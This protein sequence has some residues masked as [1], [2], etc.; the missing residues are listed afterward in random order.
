MRMFLGVKS[1]LYYL[2]ALAIV[3]F[4][5]ICVRFPFD[6][7]IGDLLWAED[8]SIFLNQAGE[9]GLQSLMQ[10][11]AGYL[12]IYPRLFAFLVNWVGLGSAPYLLFFGWAISA[13]TLFYVVTTRLTSLGINRWVA[14]VPAI[15]VFLQPN[16]GEV[17]FNITNAQWF[18]GASLAVMVCIDRSPPEGCLGYACLFVFCLTGPFSAL[19]LPVLFWRAIFDSNVY[20]H[21]LFYCFFVGLACVQLVV[22][23][24]SSRGASDQ[25]D[26]DIF[27][28]A[29]AVYVF[30]SFALEKKLLFLVVPFWIIFLSGVVFCCRSL[31]ASRREW[32]VSG[33]SLAGALVIMY[34]SGLW[35]LKNMPQILSPIGYGGR[36]FLIPYTLLIVL[37]SVLLR[38]R[39]LLFWM[40]ALFFSIICYVQFQGFGKRQLYF[41]EFLRFSQVAEG[42]VI[43]I[44]PVW[45]VYRE[46][47]VKPKYSH[48][49][50]FYTLPLAVFEHNGLLR[51]NGGVIEISSDTSDPFFVF[52]QG[53]ACQASRHMG[54]RIETQR[55][56]E[57]LAQLF[58]DSGKGFL[59]GQS[60]SRFYPAGRVKM[61]FIAPNTFGVVLRF[62][63]VGDTSISKI[64]KIDI[65]CLEE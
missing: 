4:A 32:L 13:A 56:T 47:S 2:M 17:Y 7:A 40:G 60:M 58:W 65:Y 15:L 35:A 26:K 33:V 55:E 43:P 27:H 48:P 29:Y 49:G 9:F 22:F 19:L 62:D 8:G 50:Q 14:L 64:Y 21:K 59:E 39:T 36:Y 10:P 37:F 20:K 46:W 24:N 5:V 3:F 23:V 16:G 12:L 34:L 6:N 38:G 53:P 42:V 41:N 57:G 44:N 25:I 31:N 30:L 18:L 61:D 1:S 54:L 45:S 63:P 28:W 52:K 11:Y 51:F